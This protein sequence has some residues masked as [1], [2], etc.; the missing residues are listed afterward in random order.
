MFDEFRVVNRDIIDTARQSTLDGMDVIVSAQELAILQGLI[1]SHSCRS[2]LDCD[3]GIGQGAAASGAAFCRLQPD[4]IRPQYIGISRFPDA[5]RYMFTY[6]K[7]KYVRWIPFVQIRLGDVPT[8]VSTLAASSMDLGIVHG[9]PRWVDTRAN[10]D[11]IRRV[12]Q[13]RGLILLRF[14][15][16]AEYPPAEWIATTRAVALAG[17][18]WLLHG[19]TG[20]V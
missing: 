12:I 19:H 17:G 1:V 13:P 18:S 20:A 2:V 8:A 11:A 9:Q 4:T 3:F 14:G 6:L 10:W 7:R 5:A 15:K 16:Q